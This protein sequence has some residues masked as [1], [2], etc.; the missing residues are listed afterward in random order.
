[1]TSTLGFPA[2]PVRMFQLWNI[3]PVLELARARSWSAECQG[4]Y[5]PTFGVHCV[6]GMV[7]KAHCP[8]THSHPSCWPAAN[9]DWNGPKNALRCPGFLE[10]SCIWVGSKVFAFSRP[11]KTDCDN[12]VGRTRESNDMLCISD[13]LFASPAANPA[14]LSASC[15]CWHAFGRP[16]S[17]SSSSSSSRSSSSSSSSSCE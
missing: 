2:G 14:C 9:C 15:P 11:A 3:M 8:K 12:H 10:T 7:S 6:S 17:S 5:V 1:M 4:A 16:R 13:I